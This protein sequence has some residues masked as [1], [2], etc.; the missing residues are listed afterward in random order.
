MSV[1]VITEKT[2]LVVK[3]NGVDVS[4]QA[5]FYCELNS[6]VDVG[7]FSIERLLFIE[8]VFMALFR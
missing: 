4:V 1:A 3:L 7:H 6:W 5:I 8:P 2:K